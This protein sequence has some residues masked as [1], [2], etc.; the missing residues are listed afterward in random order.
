MQLIAESIHPMSKVLG[1]CLRGVVLLVPLA[2]LGGCATLDESACA[3]GDWFTVGAN[4]ARYGHRADRIS[5][6]QRACGKHGYGVDQQAY[7]A[8]YQEGLVSYCTPAQGFH[9]GRNGSR[10]PDQC[11][12]EAARRMRQ[13]YE[14][15]SE[16]HAID[17]ELDDY[18][19]EIDKLTKEI[20][21]EKTSDTTREVALQRVR[22]VE[23]DRNRRERERDRLLDQARR[24]GYGDGR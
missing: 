16:V 9:S 1:R 13:G 19:R 5:E 3:R 10:F 22:Y 8:G 24:R 15:G 11:P 17:R 6:H 14:L 7:L 18:Q 4:D 12:V 23:T 2:L 21:D 20:R